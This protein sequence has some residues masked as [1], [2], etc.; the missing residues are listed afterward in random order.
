MPSEKCLGQMKYNVIN[1][2]EMQYLLLIKLAVL[3]FDRSTD[4]NVVLVVIK[5]ANFILRQFLNNA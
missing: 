5:N 4:L 3:L 2:P 1:K